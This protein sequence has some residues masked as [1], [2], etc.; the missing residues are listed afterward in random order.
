LDFIELKVD[1]LPDFA[2]IV[3]AELAEAGFDS[4][5]ETPQGVN[6][7]APADV[8]DESQVQEIVQ[9][10]A[11]LSPITYTFSI[12][13]RRN[14]NEEWEKNYQ[15]IYIGNQC[16]VRASF[17]QLLQQFPYEIVINPKM[18]FGTGHHETTALML[19]MQLGVDHAGKRVL[20]AGCGTGILAI[21]ACKRGAAHVDAYDIDIWAVENARENCQ[22]NGCPAI[23]IQQGTIEEVQLTEPY[24]VILANINRNVLL[25]EIPL[26][27]GKL[28]S[29]GQLLLSGF[30]EQD[31]AEL[32]RVAAESNLSLT[33][34]HIKQ[35]WAALC[36]QKQG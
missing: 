4:F 26:Y 14:W 12:M 23:G 21:M 34:Q 7:Y 11:A 2:D 27:A 13:P 25:R 9:K 29:D 32:N 6:A 15:P 30:Y 1:V 5:V 36:F 10:Y 3:V 17:H 35:H 28:A 24:E 19:E 33:A 20:D 22:L 16:V 31:I 18:S 8:F